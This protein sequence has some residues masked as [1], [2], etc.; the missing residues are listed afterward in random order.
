MTKPID[1]Y[2]CWVVHPEGDAIEAPLHLPRALM[3][4]TLAESLTWWGD[5]VTDE[6]GAVAVA[7]EGDSM[8]VACARILTDGRWASLSHE[9]AR[10]A[11]DVAL[12]V[13]T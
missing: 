11:V 4:A 9:V 1:F 10:K 2:T 6:E 3:A 12:R 13:A 7:L 5:E 8:R